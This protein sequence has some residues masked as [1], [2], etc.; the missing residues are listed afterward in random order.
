M[1]ET[2]SGGVGL[3]DYDGDG[4]MD[5]YCVQG[6]PLFADAASPQVGGAR[7][8]GD[9]LFRNRGDGSFEDVTGRSHLDA[10]TGGRGY[11]MGVA[12]GDYDN[13]GDPDL[14]V[15]RVDS[16]ALYRNR[17]DGTFED[18]TGP[19]GLAGR[20]D[21]PSSAAFADLDG[22]GDLDLYVCHYMKWDPSNPPTCRNDRGDYFYCDPSKVE[23][24]P[25]HAFRNNGGRFVDVTAESGLAEAGGR[26]LGVVACRPRRRR[27]GRPVRRQRRHGQLPVSQ[28][29]R[30][31]VRGDRARGRGGR[32]RLGRL[33]GRDG[34]GVRRP[35]RRRPA[36]PPGHQLLRRGDDVLPQPGAGSVRRPQR[37][38]GPGAGDP[39][40]AGVRHCAGG[41]GRTSAVA[42]S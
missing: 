11:G 12:V 36:R 9:R 37:S 34:R 5:V 28:Q 24:A 13:D 38:D 27:P 31:P 32:Q 19:A 18:A 42:M 33:P 21:Y 3:L 17:G 35:R 4:F 30:L 39:L 40:P 29:G 7:D 26:G 8:R 14:F 41:R 25:D 16:Y 6:G 10:I 23:P 1:P 22:D 20:R 2:M 15:T